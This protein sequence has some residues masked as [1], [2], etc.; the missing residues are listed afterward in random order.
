VDIGAC[1]WRAVPVPNVG[2]WVLQNGSVDSVILFV[3]SVDWSPRVEQSSNQVLVRWRRLGLV[4]RLHRR[5]SHHWGSIP[6]EAF[7]PRLRG[8]EIRD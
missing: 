5:L 2:A 1:V 7:K 4:L 3:W 8:K 6:S